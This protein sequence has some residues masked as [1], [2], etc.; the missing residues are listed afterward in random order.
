MLDSGAHDEK[1][2]AIPFGDPN[3]NMFKEIDE[4]P[5]HIFQEMT[6]FFSVY[7]MLENKSTVIDEAK[8][9]EE[10]RKIIEDSINRYNE[11]FENK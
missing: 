6:H 8:G 10:A 5:E 4:L 7:K 2:I 11:I 1:I 3:Y 9:P